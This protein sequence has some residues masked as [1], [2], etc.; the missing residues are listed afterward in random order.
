MTSDVKLEQAIGFL[1]AKAPGPYS[2][3][4]KLIEGMQKDADEILRF[5]AED[6]LLRQ[7]QGKAQ[8]CIELLEKLRR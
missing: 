6:T 7:N 1:S 4:I 5:A 3:I 2:E 8:L